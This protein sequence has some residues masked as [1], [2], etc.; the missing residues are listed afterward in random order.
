LIKVKLQVVTFSNSVA[1]FE[2]IQHLA[3]YH[4]CKLQALQ[5][6]VAEH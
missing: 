2:Y 1:E 6:E 3:M 5:S 4:A